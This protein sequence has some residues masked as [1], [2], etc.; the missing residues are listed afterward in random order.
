MTRVLA[1]V[2]A[3]PFLLVAL[4]VGAG[5]LWEDTLGRLLFSYSVLGLIPMVV[6]AFLLIV[7]V[8]VPLVMV[9]ARLRRLSLLVLVLAGGLSGFLP[10]V[11][12]NWSTLIDDKLRMGFRLE[13]LADGHPVIL[14]GLACGALFWLLAVFRNPELQRCVPLRR[15]SAA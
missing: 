4:L 13:K 3:L 8:F 7:A 9:A 11:F 12:A 5:Y 6:A 10:V 1:T 2:A 15:R 14:L